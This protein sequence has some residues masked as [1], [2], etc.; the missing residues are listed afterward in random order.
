[1]ATYKTAKPKFW[2]EHLT[3]LAPLKNNLQQADSAIHKAAKKAGKKAAKAAAK[4]P[5]KAALLA[6]TITAAKAVAKNATRNMTEYREGSVSAVLFPTTVEQLAEI[7]HIANTHRVQLFPVSTGKNWGLGSQMPATGTATV[8]NLTQMNKV[9]E[10]NERWRYAVIEPGVTQG[11]LY[12]YLTKHHPTLMLPPTG[13]ARATSVVGN[14]LDRGA[15]I[16][17]HRYDHMKGVEV[18]LGSGQVVRTGNWHFP[19]VEVQKVPLQYY[20]AG[21]GP[22]ITGLFSQSNL[23]IVTKMVVS[24]VPRKP[25]MVFSLVFDSKHLEQ[26]GESVFELTESGIL[27]AGCLITNLKDPRTRYGAGEYG[28]KWLAAARIKTASLAPEASEAVLRDHFGELGALQFWSTEEEY[29]DEEVPTPY[30][31]VLLRMHKGEPTDHSMITL[32][33]LSGIPYKDQVNIDVD[34]EVMGFVCAL[35]AVPLS[36]PYF[37]RI[38]DC[39]MEVSKRLEIDPYFNFLT[40]SA[41]SC[42]GF[43]RVFFDRNDKKMVERVHRWNRESHEALQAIG[44]YPYRGNIRDLPG[45]YHEKDTYWQTIKDLKGVMDPNN[46]LAPGKYAPA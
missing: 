14:V 32:Y 13:S 36:G 17:G 8:V 6:A 30:V 12:Q 29:S 7:V 15:S 26:L 33:Q 22:D 24:L 40:F 1:M 9:L 34:P 41:H 28:Q 45:S 18:V 3:D 16:R 27:D 5:K 37:Q 2:R 20:P 10:V 43:F 23:G 38:I 21:L 31:K 19:E 44:I 46:I 11:Q 42:E 25:E 4:K 35:P 39:V